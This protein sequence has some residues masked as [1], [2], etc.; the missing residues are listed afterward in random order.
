MGAGV[1]SRSVETMEASLGSIGHDPEGVVLPIKQVS[2]HST[3]SI[4]STL[5]YQRL[6]S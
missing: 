2:I 5:I 3:V 6:H 1:M 4:V